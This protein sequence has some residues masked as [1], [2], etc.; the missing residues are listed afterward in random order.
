[1]KT[2]MIRALICL[3]IAV[4]FSAAA[5]AQDATTRPQNDG[6]GPTSRPSRRQ[7]YRNNGRRF[8]RQSN[9]PQ[10]NTPTQPTLWE[11][12]GERNIFVKG[13]QSTPEPQELP[14]Q[15]PQQFVNTPAATQLLL[16]G[17]AITDYGK[18]ALLENQQEFT[19]IR[20]KIGD[21]I[22]DGKVVDITLDSLEYQNRAGRIIRVEIGYNLAGGEVWGAAGSA[23]SPGSSTQP[24]SG[25]P[26]QPG[27]SMEDYLRRRRASELVH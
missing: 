11:Q 17:V 25:A 26:R 24:A 6:N 20:V 22:A 21:P 5:I 7:D 18:I 13:D 10:S 12:V 2:N 3:C 4:L 14:P 19:V 1:M 27:E 9:T 23:S 16:T 8:D 15:P